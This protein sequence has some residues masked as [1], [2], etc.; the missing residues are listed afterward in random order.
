VTSSTPGGRSVSGRTGETHKAWLRE[1]GETFRARVQSPPWSQFHG[2]KNAID[3][4][5]QDAVAVLDA[6]H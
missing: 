5:L 6:F 3:D 1:R 2:Y 4:Q